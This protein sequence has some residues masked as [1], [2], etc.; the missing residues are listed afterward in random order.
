V[1]ATSEKNVYRQ[2]KNSD[3]VIAKRMKKHVPKKC[4]DLD[5]S[6]LYFLIIG[7]H[8]KF[9]REKNFLALGVCCPGTTKCVPHM[10]NH[11]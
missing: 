11:N 3:F 4:T 5:L 6:L 8:S 2:Q 10:S 7:T 1:K 9:A